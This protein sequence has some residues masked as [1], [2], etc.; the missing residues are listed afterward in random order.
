MLN[1][2]RREHFS[3]FS[4]CA[5]QLF[6]LYSLL[7]LPKKCSHKAKLVT[8]LKALD[9]APGDARQRASRIARFSLYEGQEWG[10][11]TIGRRPRGVHLNT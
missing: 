7:R 6:L 1:A 10:L 5:N 9:S 2:I 11:K 3:Y 4:Q 8:G